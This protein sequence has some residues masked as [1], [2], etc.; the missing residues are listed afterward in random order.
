MNQP[1]QL[2][3]L[4]YQTSTKNPLVSIGVPVYNEERFLRHTLDSLLAQNYGDLE[5]IISDNASTDGTAQICQEYLSKDDRVSYYRNETNVGSLINFSKAFERAQGEFFMWASGHDLYHAAFVSR[6]VDTMKQD[7][8]IVLCH[9]K[10]LWIDTNGQP[11]EMLV[12]SLDTRGVVS[13]SSRLNLVLW[14]LSMLAFPICG[15]HRTSALRQTQLFQNVAAPDVALLAE[16]S[17]IGTFAHISE[18]LFYARKLSDWGSWRRYMEKHFKFKGG[19]WQ[20]QLL[21]WRML[22]AMI[23]SVNR[24][25]DGFSDKVIGTASVIACVFWKYH[26][27][28]WGL[29]S[30]SIR[31]PRREEQ[32][33]LT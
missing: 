24:H 13:Q 23:G 8:S 16:L 19:G 20:A 30:L 10:T 18:P 2:S 33:S 27:M 9:A 5:I 28:F 7:P 31:K 4:Q 1:A 11:L 21:F 6:C 22:S 29:L 26:W 14:K 32:P 3:E 25:V 12:D 15:M 17:L